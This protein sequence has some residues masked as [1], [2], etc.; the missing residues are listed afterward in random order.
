M[1]PEPSGKSNEVI[2]FNAICKT[3]TSEEG[4]E[5]VSKSLFNSS[6]FVSMRAT[7]VIT[8]STCKSS[9][10]KPV[11]THDVSTT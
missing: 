10:S 7:A 1:T 2:S 9:G 11:K 4:E 3:I 5:Y 6:L 8:S